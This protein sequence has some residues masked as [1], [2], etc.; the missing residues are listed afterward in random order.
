MKKK[1]T[2]KANS[3]PFDFKSLTEY[4]VIFTHT[5]KRALIMNSD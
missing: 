5:K 3:I 2:Q 1:A 4:I